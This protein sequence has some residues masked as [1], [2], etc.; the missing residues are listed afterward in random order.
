ME[1]VDV[2]VKKALLETIEAKDYEGKYII[3]NSR[4]WIGVHPVLIE[5]LN[6][7]EKGKMKAF[8]RYIKARF[9]DAG[10]TLRVNINGD[11]LRRLYSENKV[12]HYTGNTWRDHNDSIDPSTLNGYI[13]VT[14]Q[15]KTSLTKYLKRAQQQSIKIHAKP[16][17]S[18][19]IIHQ[20]ESTDR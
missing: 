1:D 5:D 9:K 2:I 12:L 7:I 17:P 16:H 14:H 20:R 13:E 15:F 18:R 11:D 4:Q 19:S 3:T 10:L 8:E 6:V